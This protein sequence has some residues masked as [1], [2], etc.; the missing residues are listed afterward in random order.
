MFQILLIHHTRLSYSLFLHS[1]LYNAVAIQFTSKGLLCIW[2]YSVIPT[3]RKLTCS[4]P[5]DF[6]T[7]VKS[8]AGILKA[9]RNQG[10]K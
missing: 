8:E 7:T 4:T 9:K 6:S 2:D 5:T 3:S 1:V 10:P